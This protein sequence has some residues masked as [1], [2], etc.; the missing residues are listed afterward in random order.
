MSSRERQAKYLQRQRDKGLVPITVLVP[1]ASVA[2]L[3]LLAEALR[4]D[5]SLVLTPVLRGLRGF[6][7]AKAVIA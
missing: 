5:R 4:A 6:V 1:P 7:S 2:D 3:K